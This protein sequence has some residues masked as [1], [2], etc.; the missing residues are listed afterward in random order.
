MHT[1]LYSI[2]HDV[3]CTAPAEKTR[4]R[5]HKKSDERELSISQ[6]GIANY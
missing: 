2:A 1:A 5:E 6:I 4:A 3:Q